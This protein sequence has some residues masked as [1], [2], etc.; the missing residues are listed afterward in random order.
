MLDIA[1][2]CAEPRVVHVTPSAECCTVKEFET[3]LIRSQ[4]GNKAPLLEV[5]ARVPESTK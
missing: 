5:A 4:Y 2:V 1:T 3:R